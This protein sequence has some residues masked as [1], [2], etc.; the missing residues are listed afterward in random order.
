MKRLRG[1]QRRSSAWIGFIRLSTGNEEACLALKRDDEQRVASL[2]SANGGRLRSANG[3]RLR[4]AN[5]GRLRP[6]NGGTHRMNRP[7]IEGDSQH[8]KDVSMVPRGMSTSEADQLQMAFGREEE[9]RR[10]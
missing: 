5:G 3:G 10:R 8:G 2:R 1:Y 7:R 6:A 9:C 4:S